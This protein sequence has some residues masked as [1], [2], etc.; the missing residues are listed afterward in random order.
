MADPILDILNCSVEGVIQPRAPGE[1]LA[2]FYSIAQ[3]LLPGLNLPYDVNTSLR[4]SAATSSPNFDINLPGGVTIPAIDKPEA[5]DMIG[6]LQPIMTALSAA[7]MVLGPAKIIIDIIIAI[8]NVFCAFPDP[9]KIAEAIVKLMAALIPL[10]GLFPITAGMLLLLEVAKSV[11][12]ILTA[13]LSQL[14]PMME[15][16]IENVQMAIA[17]INGN[18]PTAV[19]AITAKICSVAQNMIDSLAILAPINKILAIINA[20]MRL[21]SGGICAP[22]SNGEGGDCCDD[23]PEIVRN[24][25]VGSATVVSNTDTTFKIS[26]NSARFKPNYLGAPTVGNAIVGANIPVARPIDSVVM[27]I[28]KYSSPGA[29]SILGSRLVDLTYF[30]NTFTALLSLTLPVI[31]NSASRTDNYI[32][33]N[34]NNHNFAIGDKINILTSGPL[35]NTFNGDFDIVDTTATTFTVNSAGDDFAPVNTSALLIRKHYLMSDVE[36]SNGEV[37]LTLNGGLGELNITGYELVANE[38]DILSNNL[39]TMGCMSSVSIGRGSFEQ[40]RDIDL[41]AAVTTNNGIFPAGTRWDS[42]PEVLLGTEIPTIDEVGIKQAIADFAANPLDGGMDVVYNKINFEIDR[43][44]DIAARS[45]CL[46][47]SS[48]NSTLTADVSVVDFSVDAVATISYQPRSKDNKPLLIGIPSNIDINAV[49]TTNHG[50]LSDTAFDIST[51]TYTAT[52]SADS[53]GVATVRAFFITTDVCST[54][55]DTNAPKV[56]NVQFVDGTQR[57]RRASRQ[58]IQSAGGRRR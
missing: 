25:P 49:F 40:A 15:L 4:N 43:F 20:F 32:L 48:L 5:E 39:M 19:D 44:K 56:V 36:L 35:S 23:C 58:Y 50:L 52:L 51:G 3:G 22:G 1:A 31:A 10:L 9:F 38:S 30:R 6:F 2:A 27:P 18:N 47:V 16:I 8:I 42:A 29:G 26:L 53:P 14:L 46:L 45:L 55:Q 24:P 13:I 54:P 21:A 7:M 12:L 28:T 17:A 11:I 33:F 37:I 34:S 57:A 41:T